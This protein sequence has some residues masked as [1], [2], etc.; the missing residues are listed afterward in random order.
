MLNSSFCQTFDHMCMKFR[1]HKIKRF[2]HESFL[3]FRRISVRSQM[4]RPEMPPGY[5]TWM[6]LYFLFLTSNESYIDKINLWLY[7]ANV[8]QVY[9]QYHQNI[10]NRLYLKVEVSSLIPPTTIPIIVVARP[11]HIY[12]PKHHSVEN[13]CRSGGSIESDLL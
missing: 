8:L 5:K 12:F 11:W 3:R 2:L 4:L 1:L 13:I 6:N 10:S 7:T 9:S